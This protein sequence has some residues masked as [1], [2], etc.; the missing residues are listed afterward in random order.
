MGSREGLPPLDEALSR[1]THKQT[2]ELTAFTEGIA[3]TD[4]PDIPTDGVY[5]Q[6]EVDDTGAPVTSTYFDCS[7]EL[8]QATEDVAGASMPDASNE[9]A[10]GAA[11]PRGEKRSAKKSTQ[12][13]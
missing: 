10:T 3:T 5:E 6:L 11:T 4:L 9:G 8:Y 7:P 2:L 13:S 12:N 1:S